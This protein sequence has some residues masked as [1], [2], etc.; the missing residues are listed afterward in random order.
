MRVQTATL[1]HLRSALR[2][3]RI[4]AVA[5]VILAGQGHFS[6]SGLTHPDEISGLGTRENIRRSTG[7]ILDEF[8]EYWQQRTEAMHA[9]PHGRDPR[10]VRNWLWMHHIPLDDE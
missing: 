7:A 1:T 5:S 3:L 4:S 2:F 10:V 8:R 6:R 9:I